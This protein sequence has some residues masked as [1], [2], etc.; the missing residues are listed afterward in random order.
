MIEQLKETGWSRA[1]EGNRMEHDRAAEG[2]RME[3][4]R[5]AEGNNMAQD[6]EA[7]EIACSSIRHHRK[8]HGAGQSC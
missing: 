7:Q 2:N 8:Q 6:R 4:D 3:Y 5:A 1:A